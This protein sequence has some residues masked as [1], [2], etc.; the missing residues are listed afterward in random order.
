[1]K[2]V[3]DTSAYSLAYA[4]HEEAALILKSADEIIIPPQVIAE[5]RYGFCL[6]T[7]QAENEHILAR[8][9]HAKKVRRAE[10]DNTTIDLYVDIAINARKQ[11]KAL[12]QND[13]WIAAQAAKHDARLVTADKDF[14]YVKNKKFKLKLLEL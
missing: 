3:F 5:L 11:G 7:R 2:C 13:Y 6:G 4:G 9:L 8:F 1:M 12:S 10:I 14:S